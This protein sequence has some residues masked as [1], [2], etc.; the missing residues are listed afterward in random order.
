MTKQATACVAL[1][2]R[3]LT[4]QRYG[5]V[6]SG[7]I[8]IGQIGAAVKILAVIAGVAV[9][10]KHWRSHGQHGRCIRSVGRVAIGAIV[11]NWR[12]IPQERTAFFRVAGIAGLID[13]LFHHQ[14]WPC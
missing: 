6:R 4:A 2:G 1:C 9:L 14:L 3:A 7:H 10:A 12:V 13:S 5:A 8:S 11:R